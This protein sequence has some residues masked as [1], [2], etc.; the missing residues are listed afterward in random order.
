MAWWNQYYYIVLWILNDGHRFRSA[1]LL[2]LMSY[3][4]NDVHRTLRAIVSKW[5]ASLFALSATGKWSLDGRSV[6]SRELRM[7]FLVP[8]SILGHLEN[9]CCRE[10]FHRMAPLSRSLETHRTLGWD[11]GYDK[12]YSFELSS[13]SIF[14]NFHTLSFLLVVLGFLIHFAFWRPYSGDDIS[15]GI[16]GILVKI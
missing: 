12:K 5:I 7:R 6:L 10:R 1:E 16:I 14:D 11:W 9:C 2:Q 15:I 8:F 4:I 3:G 13:I